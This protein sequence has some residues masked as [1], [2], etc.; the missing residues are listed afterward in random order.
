MSLLIALASVATLPVVLGVARE[1][2]LG[3]RVDKASMV[4]VT[5]A[6]APRV[7][8]ATTELLHT[9]DVSSLLLVGGSLIVLALI[10][11]RLGAALG[12]AVLLAGANVTTQVLKDFLTDADLVG[13]SASATSSFPSGHATVAMSIA[14][15]AVIALPAQLRAV[16]GLAGAAYAAAVGVALVALGWHFPSDVA[17]G[18][19]VSMAWAALVVAALAVSKERT[20]GARP[21]IPPLGIAAGLLV[22]AL[23]FASA[24]AVAVSRHPEL[25]DYG[26]LHT[27]F[28]VASAAL[29]ALSLVLVGAVAA[30]AGS[31][32]RAT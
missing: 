20:S 19:L 10:L 4:R 32:V 31:R 29:A 16:A 21:L 26:R 2:D 5:E 7:H 14:L 11:G 23:A 27:T 17:G 8:R 3:L 22:L 13:Q 12:V 30:V 24:V 28:F 25:L 15:S 18:Y 1:T 9:I 6:T